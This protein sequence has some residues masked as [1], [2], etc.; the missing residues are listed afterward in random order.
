MCKTG[1]VLGEEACQGWQGEGASHHQHG[2]PGQDLE[3]AA[4]QVMDENMT[5]TFHNIGLFCRSGEVPSANGN[6]NARGLA[7]IA[8][9]M[10]G[11]GSLGE[12][13]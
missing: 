8:A 6:C 12:V 13:S 4:N 11:R 10:A 2:P 5:Q 3:H 9:A 1:F 7:R